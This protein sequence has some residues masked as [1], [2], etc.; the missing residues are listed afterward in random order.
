MMETQ[1]KLPS[2]LNSQSDYILYAMTRGV[3]ITK[4][5]ALTRFRTVNLG[6]RISELRQAGWPIVTRMIPT[7]SGKRIGEYYLDG[8]AC[9]D[10]DGLHYCDLCLGALRFVSGHMMNKEP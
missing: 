2:E 4:L 10:C 5:M 3:R 8:Y 1:L 9:A 7:P 6:Q